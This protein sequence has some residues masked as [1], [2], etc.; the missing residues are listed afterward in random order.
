MTEELERI[1]AEAVRR[2][3]ETLE[4]EFLTDEERILEAQTAID[5]Y[6]VGRHRLTRRRRS[7]V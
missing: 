6:F 1:A 7:D 3:R 5:E 4:D 2:I